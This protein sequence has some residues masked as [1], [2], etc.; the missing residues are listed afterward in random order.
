LQ[1]PSKDLAFLV[2]LRLLRGSGG[3]EILPSFWEDNYI[4]LLPGEKREVAVH[5]RKKDVGEAKP[6]LAVDGFNVTST[7]VR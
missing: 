1:N 3:P 5:V 6:V 2:R 4:S 7:T